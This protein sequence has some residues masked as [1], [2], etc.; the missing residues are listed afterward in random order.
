M[1]F[2]ISYSIDQESCLLC[3]FFLLW[4]FIF[5]KILL[6]SD[7]WH[8][9]CLWCKNR[10][11]NNGINNWTDRLSAFLIILLEVSIDY[12]EDVYTITLTVTLTT[13]DPVGGNVSNSGSLKRGNPWSQPGIRQGVLLL[14]VLNYTL[15]RHFPLVD[16]R[17]KD[18]ISLIY[19]FIYLLEY[20]K[21]H[22]II[23]Y[24]IVNVFQY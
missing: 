19:V 18:F 13:T 22:R 9:D 5:I 15:F 6:L 23:E 10:G 17:I 4:V 8:I 11:Y 16:E 3:M 24:I 2:A 1:N 20:S 14:S 12:W 21:Q 7:S